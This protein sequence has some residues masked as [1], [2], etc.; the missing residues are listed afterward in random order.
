MSDTGKDAP[1]AVALDVDRMH[2]TVYHHQPQSP[3][4]LAEQDIETRLF[5]ALS[6]FAAQEAA[7]NA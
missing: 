3:S 7:R 6:R 4:P 2:C 1:Q 5:Q